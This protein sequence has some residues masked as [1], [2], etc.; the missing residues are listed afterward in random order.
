MD[1]SVMSIDL[2]SHLVSWNG[3]ASSGPTLKASRSAPRKLRDL[4]G[5][6]Y[7][8]YEW[9]EFQQG[10]PSIVQEW[11]GPSVDIAKP[12]RV[13]EDKTNKFIQDNEFVGGVHVKIKLE[14]SHT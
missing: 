11:I 9:E 3:G 13:L 4:H 8:R 12:L 6:E 14:I 1:S 2:S 5:N 7:V 10:R